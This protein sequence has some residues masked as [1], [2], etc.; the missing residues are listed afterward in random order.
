M[1]S[2]GAAT[3]RAKFQFLAGRYGRFQV[4][5]EGQHSTRGEGKGQARVGIFL[6]KALASEARRITSCHIPWHNTD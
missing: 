5:Q 3:L 2:F 6:Q 4:G 1:L